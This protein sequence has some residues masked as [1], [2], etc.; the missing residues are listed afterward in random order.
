MTVLL[1][2]LGSHQQ[3]QL[4]DLPLRPWSRGAVEPLEWAVA[5]FSPGFQSSPHHQRQL[6]PAAGTRRWFAFLVYLARTL[7]SWKPLA[8]WSV[9]IC[10]FS[11]QP[12]PSSCEFHQASPIANAFYNLASQHKTLESPPGETSILLDC[13]APHGWHHFHFYVASKT[14]SDGLVC[15]RCS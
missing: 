1:L 4:Q 7:A 3:R 14:H 15:Q 5:L 8:W 13:W 10:P 11:I 9:P 2:V 6:S 12:S